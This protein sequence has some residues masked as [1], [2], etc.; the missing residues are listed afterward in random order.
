MKEHKH[1]QLK[2]RAENEDALYAPNSCRSPQ[3]TA[4]LVVDVQPEYWTDSPS[5]RRDFAGFP[6][7]M[8]SLL[9][10]CRQ[11]C[12]KIIWVRTDYRVSH[13]PWLVQLER[14]RGQAPD[15][16]LE[17]PYEPPVAWEEF[18]SP[19]DG[20]IVIPKRHWSATSGTPLKE[21]LRASEI[22]TVMVCG[23]ITSVCVQLTA[24]GLFE[25]GY[26]TIVVSDACAD[27]GRARHEAALSLYG[28]Y[29]YETVTSRELEEMA[30]SIPSAPEA[31][32]EISLTSVASPPHPL[33]RQRNFVSSQ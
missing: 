26:R 18:A 29:M 33:S 19:L 31:K 4:L 17:M 21:V 14:L 11:H 3:R 23:L 12:I 30:E 28:N 9:A 2:W 7:R 1:Q 15:F 16:M 25:A 32:E 20:E 22:D 5:I 13:S 6:D 24:Y 27:R 10:T 8:R